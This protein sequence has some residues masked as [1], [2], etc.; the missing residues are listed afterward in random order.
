MKA[1]ILAAGLGERM[2]PLTDKTPKPLLT[3]AAKP[4]IYYHLERLAEAGVKEV[5]VNISHLADQI[6]E[7]LGAGEQWGLDI[8]FSREAEPLET[9]GGII[10][11]LTLLGTEP[12]LLVN[13]DVW[14]DYPFTTL[15]AH[16]LGENLVHMVMVDNPPQHERGDFYLNAD[17]KLSEQK[18]SG[19]PRLTYAGIGVYSPQ[20]FAGCAQ[21]KLALKPLLLE[22][23]AN[24]QA[25][26]EHYWGEWVD[27]G[28]PERLRQ[29]NQQGMR[30][31]R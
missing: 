1:M 18:E 23:M 17:G 9:A 8:Q 28:T 7:N 3:V 30:D 14:S 16:N 19:S 6:E 20:L 26:G 5:V 15:A 2:R 27:V 11:A 22:A 29:L 31:E 24:R 25:S 12:F 21:G 13:G 10:Q 4:L